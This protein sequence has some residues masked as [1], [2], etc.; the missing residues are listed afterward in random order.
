M[1]VL[2]ETM[3]EQQ[4]A[5]AKSVEA[6]K[7]HA[8]QEKK[9]KQEEERRKLEQ[10]EDKANRRKIR[11]LER[12]TAKRL[13]E[14][15]P[16]IEKMRKSAQEWSEKAKDASGKTFGQW[17]GDERRKEREE[18]RQVNSKLKNIT[19]AQDRRRQIG[20]RIFDRNGRIR[21]SAN[22]QDIEA[23][24]K[25]GEYIGLQSSNDPK[26]QEAARREQ[27][28]IGKRIFDRNG[29]LRRSANKQDVQRWKDL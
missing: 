12:A 29:R 9:R 27:D 17:S 2:G 14:M 16:E 3:R 19:N 20:E 23:Y 6:E 24:R 22:K 5:V 18:E 1:K 15:L 26:L 25:I 4:R 8:E 13:S 21:R 28:K 10:E 11:E 7:K